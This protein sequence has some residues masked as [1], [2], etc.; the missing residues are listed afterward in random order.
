VQLGYHLY[1]YWPWQFDDYILGLLHLARPREW[2]GNRY[3]ELEFVWKGR[4]ASWLMLLTPLHPP[5]LAT[6]GMFL[7][8]LI[9]HGRANVRRALAEGMLR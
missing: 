6:G 2:W 3:E 7:V 9:R 8:N 5:V 1:V 4:G